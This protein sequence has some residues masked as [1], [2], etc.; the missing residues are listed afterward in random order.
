ML[1][2]CVYFDYGDEQS[3]L[4]EKTG[5]VEMRSAV[6]IGLGE[7]DQQIGLVE[8]SRVEQS[9]KTDFVKL[10]AFGK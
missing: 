1:E 7:A 5:F 10:N 4:V 2:T 3:K 9:S 6:T 8:Q